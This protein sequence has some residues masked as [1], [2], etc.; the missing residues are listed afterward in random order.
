MPFPIVPAP[1]T[2]TVLIASIDKVK[3]P[4]Q[5]KIDIDEVN[6]VKEVKDALCARSRSSRESLDFSPWALAISRLANGAENRSLGSLSITSQYLNLEFGIVG[7]V[8]ATT[9][10]AE[11]R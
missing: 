11:K 3:A 6:E 8:P 7:G 9:G 1:S 2:A 10:E 5:A 4:E